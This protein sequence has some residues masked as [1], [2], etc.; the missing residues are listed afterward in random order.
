[1]W[2]LFIRSNQHRAVG[3]GVE[4][5][6]AEQEIKGEGGGLCGC[7]LLEAINTGCGGLD[8][9]DWVRHAGET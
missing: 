9:K 6:G 5:G 4:W 7:Y 2:L 3:Q 1:M 8:G